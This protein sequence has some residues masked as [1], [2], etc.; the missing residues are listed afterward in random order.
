MLGNP[1]PCL[2]PIWLLLAAALVFT[3]ANA[4]LLYVAISSQPDCISHL[5]TKAEVS[6]QYR[7][8]QP[9]C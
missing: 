2:R 4:H 6:G 3:G 8:A 9:A 1:S 5:K 7:A